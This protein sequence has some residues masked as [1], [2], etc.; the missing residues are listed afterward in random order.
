MSQTAMP[1]RG[2]AAADEPPETAAQHARPAAAQ[3]GKII[4]IAGVRD[5]DADEK[6]IPSRNS[7]WSRRWP[8]RIAGRS[9]TPRRCGFCSI[10]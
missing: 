9:M 8:R 6:F 3:N 5:L 2:D 1:A 4:E 7:R 10:T